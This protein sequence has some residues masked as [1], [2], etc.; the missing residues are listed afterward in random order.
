MLAK[1]LFLGGLADAVGEDA[2]AVLVAAD[3]RR[4]VTG[5]LG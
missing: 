4:V 5:G 2:D 1:T 3:G